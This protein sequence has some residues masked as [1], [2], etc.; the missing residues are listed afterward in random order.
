M[1]FGTLDDPSTE[2]SRL[3]VSRKAIS[4]MPETGN[5]PH[6]YYLS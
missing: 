5:E 6:V 3:L 4:L 1:H 2:V